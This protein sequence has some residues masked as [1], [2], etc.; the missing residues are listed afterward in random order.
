MGTAAERAARA[1]AKTPGAAPANHPQ[2]K[3]RLAKGDTATVTIDVDTFTF[4]EQHL[5]ATTGGRL[6]EYD[7]QGRC[8]WD[9]N[10]S[11]NGSI[12][13]LIRA[14]VVLRRTRPAVT[15]EQIWALRDEDI[16]TVAA[17][18][19]VKDSSPEA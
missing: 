17:S 8:V 6:T 3:I 10:G 1:G 11:E 16:T 14:W 9:V 13:M 12:R 19:K 18:K 15:W 7:D 2:V 4:A 5:V